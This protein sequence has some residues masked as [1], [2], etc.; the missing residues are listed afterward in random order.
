[1]WPMEMHVVLIVL[2]NFIIWFR[3]AIVTLFIGESD[4]VGLLDYRD[5]PLWQIR[6][7]KG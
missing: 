1:M 7:H 5:C 4:I 2:Y 6:I 3:I